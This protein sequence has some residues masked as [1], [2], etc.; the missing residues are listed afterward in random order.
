MFNCRLYGKMAE[1]V[2]T[3]PKLASH[4][5]LCEKAVHRR[6][7]QALGKEC[8]EKATSSCS[9]LPAAHLQGGLT[10]VK[11]QVPT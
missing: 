4:T 8:W 11:M 5:G 6:S 10:G 9:C 3:C 7:H 2:D 1:A